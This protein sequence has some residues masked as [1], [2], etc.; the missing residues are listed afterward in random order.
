M[1]QVRWSLWLS[2]PHS[3]P[4]VNAVKRAGGMGGDGFKRKLRAC[5]NT[6]PRIVPARRGPRPTQ[7]WLPSSAGSPRNGPG[8]SPSRSRSRHHHRRLI[9]LGRC[10]HH[11]AAPEPARRPPATTT[12]RTAGDVC[13]YCGCTPPEPLWHGG[14]PRSSKMSRGPGAIP[15]LGS[16]RRPRGTSCPSGVPAPLREPSPRVSRSCGGG[17]QSTSRTQ[18][19]LTNQHSVLPMPGDR[20]HG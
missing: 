4:T 15:A 7:S 5:S 17:K 16:S 19:F 12:I 3:T 18:S 20:A 11:Q 14:P 2:W 8:T 1:R 10:C 13:W 9:P 6:R